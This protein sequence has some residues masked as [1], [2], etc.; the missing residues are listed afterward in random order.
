VRDV[1]LSDVPP[2]L[3]AQVRRRVRAIRQYLSPTKSKEH[4][5]RYFADRLEISE[6]RFRNMVAAWRKYH[7]PS[8][9][10]GAN[11]ARR[12]PRKLEPE[13]A[14]VVDRVREKAVP[15]GRFSDIMRS[16]RQQCAELSLP[17]P[18]RTSVARHL[19]E[20]RAE[21]PD[22]RPRRASSSSSA[23]PAR[24]DGPPRLLIDH[25]D[26]DL[27]V[28]DTDGMAAAANVTLAVLLPE[29]AI[30]AHFVSTGHLT[31]QS[32]AQVLLKAL[33]CETIGTPARALTY[34]PGGESGWSALE[35]ALRSA[36]ISISE[37]ERASLLD[38]K[39]DLRSELTH[40]LCPQA[41]VPA[42]KARLPL[43]R[44]MARIGAAI[45]RYNHRFRSSETG[46][47]IPPFAIARRPKTAA[48]R[49]RLAEIAKQRM[50]PIRTRSSVRRP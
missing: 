8:A 30:V 2:M 13:M 49:A 17:P 5:A 20:Q 15:G 41:G 36:D 26:L 40:L 29:H 50:G 48:A 38:V 47:S 4:T 27:P 7:K 9:L 25:L 3:R 22:A 42:L 46:P 21:K 23:P 6:A 19:A 16:L 45:D 43:A 11:Y 12:L 10:P 14:S 33:G 24:Y 18:P 34:R 39:A 32:A 37:P 31:P 44:A 1:D 35:D 28:F